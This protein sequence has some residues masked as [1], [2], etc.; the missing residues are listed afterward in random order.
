M[1]QSNE[2]FNPIK[3]RARILKDNI[4]VLKF[5][6]ENNRTVDIN[7]PMHN[8]GKRAKSTRGRYWKIIFRR[9]Y[10]NKSSALKAEYFLKNNSL[11]RKKIKKDCRFNGALCT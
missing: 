1:E 6:V 8:L 4:I 11:I 5:F 3:W 10:L 2:V 9:R 7:L